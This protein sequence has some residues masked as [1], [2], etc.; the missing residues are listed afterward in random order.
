[1]VVGR[2]SGQSGKSSNLYFGTVEK[3]V[4]VGG[5]IEC[6]HPD[7]AKSVVLNVDNYKSYVCG[8][9]SA[10]NYAGDPSNPVTW[11]VFNAVY[12]SDAL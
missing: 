8:G 6:V 10:N 1:M 12:K 2:F 4:Y 7:H 11:Q 5:T 9:G 3:P